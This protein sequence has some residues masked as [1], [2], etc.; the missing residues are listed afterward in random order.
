[1]QTATQKLTEI[2]FWVLLER[3]ENIKIDE[4]IS[5]WEIDYKR[6]QKII[7][8][9]LKKWFK[10][11]M[12]VEYDECF[13]EFSRRRNRKDMN[14]FMSKKLFDELRFDYSPKFTS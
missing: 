4:F 2:F 3:Y 6:L 8:K 7:D 9:W 1:M 10:L 14:K 5:G 11:D 13:M 12:D